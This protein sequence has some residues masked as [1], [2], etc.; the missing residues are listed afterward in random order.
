[1]ALVPIS[2]SLCTALALAI[3]TVC[4]RAFLGYICIRE[5]EINYFGF[6]W[7]KGG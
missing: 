3:L 6:A 1:M 5:F 4:T 7:G 2:E